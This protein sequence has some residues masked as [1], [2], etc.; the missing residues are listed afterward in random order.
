MSVMLSVF[1]TFLCCCLVVAQE[2][3]IRVRYQDTLP[4]PACMICQL[5]CDTCFGTDINGYA[6]FHATDSAGVLQLSASGFQDTL[7]Y[8]RAGIDTLVIEMSEVTSI[9]RLKKIT[10][11]SNR[12]Y[13]EISR[14]ESRSV[15]FTQADILHTAGAAG[16]VSR[17]IA[18]LPSTVASI[19]EGFDNTLYVRGGRPSEILFL[20]DGIEFENIN[21]FSKSSGSGG[22][23]GFINSEGCRA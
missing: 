11:T 18:T 9:E 16:D 4:I 13:R 8:Y 10:V 5:T 19:G 15:Q 20:V 2:V 3:S 23:I 12:I 1:W 14:L 22:P 21:H 6:T 17:Y 7:L